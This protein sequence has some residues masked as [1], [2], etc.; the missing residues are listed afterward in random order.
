MRSIPYHAHKSTN[1]IAHI[2]DI[3][4][5]PRYVS[6]VC[7]PLLRRWAVSVMAS[8]PTPAPMRRCAF[9]NRPPSHYLHDII[10]DARRLA[11]RER[12]AERGEAGEG[13]AGIKS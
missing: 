12:G 2:V 13:R 10:G 7:E 11:V 4:A 1:E 3:G 9:E 5:S 8:T 6:P